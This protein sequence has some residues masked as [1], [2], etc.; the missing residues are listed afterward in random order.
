ME[1][2]Y[3]LVA[4]AFVIGLF[5]LLM[6]RLRGRGRPGHAAAGTVYELLNEDRRNAIEIIIEERAEWRDPEDRDGD[7]PQLESPKERR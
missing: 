6:K 2:V 1:L 3:P 5:V 7:L 4:A